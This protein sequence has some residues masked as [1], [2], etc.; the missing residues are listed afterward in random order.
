MLMNPNELDGGEGRRKLKF[1]LVPPSESLSV[2]EGI[3]K[4]E[5][6]IQWREKGLTP[7]LL[8]QNWNH[9]MLGLIQQPEPAEAISPLKTR[10]RVSNE[11]ESD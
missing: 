11:L 5:V 7:S 6:P 8:E 10:S 3:I 9:A 4:D 1:I 2:V